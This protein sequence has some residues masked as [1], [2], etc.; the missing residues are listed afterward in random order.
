MVVAQQKIPYL[1]GQLLHLEYGEP[2]VVN[3]KKRVSGAETFIPLVHYIG[4]LKPVMHIVTPVGEMRGRTH[5]VVT[6][7]GKRLMASLIRTLHDLHKAG[8][9]PER[10]CA[11]DIAVTSS[12]GRVKLTNTGELVLQH[13]FP[14]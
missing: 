9:C 10:F 7:E 13:N 2:Q 4:R 14:I 8:K 6:E 5:Q 12:T 11:S 3:Y 1:H